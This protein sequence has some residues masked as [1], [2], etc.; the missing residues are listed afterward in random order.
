KHELAHIDVPGG[1]TREFWQREFEVGPERFAVWAWV[2]RNLRGTMRAGNDGI[3]VLRS[4]R[5]RVRPA[6]EPYTP[7]LPFDDAPWTVL[8]PEGGA[9]LRFHPSW[10]NGPAPFG[11]ARLS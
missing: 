11:S 8:C 9:Q 1:H 4:W 3:A 10:S 5:R 6:L 2:H 7:H